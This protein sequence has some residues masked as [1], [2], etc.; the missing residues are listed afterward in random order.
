M[1]TQEKIKSVITKNEIYHIELDFRVNIDKYNS[2]KMNNFQPIEFMFD[3]PTKAIMQ[4]V[5][6]ETHKLYGGSGMVLTS[7]ILSA[8]GLKTNHPIV[9]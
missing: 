4:K 1:T 7:Q 9:D 5:Q 6:S 2:Q 3:P 8:L